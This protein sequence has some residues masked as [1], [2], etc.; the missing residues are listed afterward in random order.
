MTDKE[1]KKIEKEYS[2]EDIKKVDKEL[3]EVLEEEVR[4][5]GLCGHYDM[6]LGPGRNI[7]E[8]MRPSMIESTCKLKNKRVGYF[9]TCSDISQTKMETA[10]LIHQKVIHIKTYYK[11]DSLEKVKAYIEHLRRERALRKTGGDNGITLPELSKP[12]KK[13]KLS[14]ITILNERGLQD[15]SAGQVSTAMKKFREVLKIDPSNQWGMLNLGTCY[16]QLFMS[17]AFLRAYLQIEKIPVMLVTSS[18]Q[19]TINRYQ[20]YWEALSYFRGVIESSASNFIKALAWCNLG[21]LFTNVDEFIASCT[22]P[23]TVHPLRISELFES[24]EDLTEFCGAK[25]WKD[26]ALACSKEATELEPA[27]PIWW[28]NLRGMYYHHKEFEN[29]LKSHDTATELIEK[30]SPDWRNSIVWKY[31]DNI[32]LAYL[33][34]TGKDKLRRGDISAAIVDYKKILARYPSHFKV[35]YNLGV[36]YG[37]LSDYQKA[38]ECYKY[39]TSL[40][41]PNNRSQIWR[42]L[43]LAYDRIGDKENAIACHIKSIEFQQSPET[44]YPTQ[45]V[46][47]PEKRKMKSHLEIL[48]VNMRQI[49]PW[50]LANIDNLS[51]P[52]LEAGFK[53]D[54]NFILN[55][56]EK[57]IVYNNTREAIKKCELVL[58]QDPGNVKALALLKKAKVKLQPPVPK[59]PKSLILLDRANKLSIRG[60]LKEAIGCLKKVVK[61]DPNLLEGWVQ[62]GMVY[63]RRRKYDK[64]ID[65]FQKAVK[66][67]R[68]DPK[69]WNK[70]AV[71]YY[72]KGEVE[73]AFNCWKIAI[74]ED[75]NYAE[76]YNKLGNYWQDK[77]E[78]TTAIRYYEKAV[79]LAPHKKEYQKSLAFARGQEAC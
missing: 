54:F 78:R 31:W 36:C 34:N 6:A 2:E 46:S 10:L 45:P 26:L 44:P 67:K 62:L 9:Y 50:L 4:I 48:R 7:I 5:C 35:F 30:A 74:T 70:L 77:G 11:L 56:A 47:K 23:V 20:F 57:N 14:Q 39:A 76:G 13:D 72:A 40:A 75:P 51:S 3:R 66:I 1:S 37:K 8:Q 61:K 53:K 58:H 16:M 21:I 15:L 42:S 12:E 79:E 17:E 60:K 25:R 71:T 28:L 22:I 64:A 18:G 68:S 38:V 41:P 27:Q 24:W 32:E 55:E 63:G 33:E 19:E 69:V 52:I 49:D 65:A 59:D 29:A 43:G 73:E